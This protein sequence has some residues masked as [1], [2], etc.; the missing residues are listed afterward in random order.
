M[1]Y[2]IIIGH[3]VDLKKYD[4]KNK[5]VIAVDKGAI[6][7]LRAGIKIDLALGDFDSINSEEKEELK[8]QFR[9]LE[10]PSEKDETDTLV[11]LKYCKDATKITIIGGIQGKRIEHFLANLSL[12]VNNPLIEIIDNNSHIYSQNSSFNVKKNNYK[13]YSFMA[14]EEATI[15]LK[16]FKYPLTDYHL[17]KNDIIG[18]SNELVADLGQVI[19]KKGRLLVICTVSDEEY[20]SKSN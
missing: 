11:A 8:K 1:E 6:D 18:I 12:L 14:L 15:T 2:V 3:D 5:Y 17:V 4:Y 9:L 7:A 16:G 10:L 13:F 19:L 20:I